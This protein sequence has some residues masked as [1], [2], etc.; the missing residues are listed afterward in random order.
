MR[1][2]MEGSISMEEQAGEKSEEMIDLRG[3][4]VETVEADEVHIQQ[5]GINRVF[6]GV[7]EMDTGGAV[8]IDAET[9]SLSESV[10]LV[11][12]AEVLDANDCSGG[13][14]VARD[15]RLTNSRAGL[16]I[17]DH[18]DLRDSSTVVL[19]ARQVNG[20]VETVLDTRGAILAGLVAGVAAGLVWLAGGLLSRRRS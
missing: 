20:P 11:V 14:L 7:V 13:V 15:M 16:A 12:R 19:L 8:T 4:I 10:G 6:A 5:A 1:D 2:A 9:V 17:A 3:T 18:A